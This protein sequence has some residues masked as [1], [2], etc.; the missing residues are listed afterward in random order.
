M[1]QVYLKI[2]FIV[3]FLTVS[4]FAIAGRELSQDY[5]GYFLN[6]DILQGIV[7][8]SLLMLVPCSLFMYFFL[9]GANKRKALFIQKEKSWQKNMAQ[10]LKMNAGLK[11]EVNRLAV[12]LKEGADILE[13][14]TL[15]LS[16]S[17][18]KNSGLGAQLNEMRLQLELKSWELKNEVN[19]KVKEDILSEEV[20][21]QEF[22]KIFP[23]ELSCYRY[24][25]DIKWGKGY[26]CRKC[27]NTKYS[28]GE[29]AYLRKCTRC[30]Y[31]E[32]VTA[33]TLFHGV[34]FS[35]NKAFYIVYTVSAPGACRIT[36]DDLS[37]SISLR[38][39]TCWSFRKKVLDRRED[40]QRQFGISY[41][42]K[43][44]S[45]LLEESMELTEATE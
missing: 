9:N 23:D 8:G 37:E 40:L 24:L 29:K 7:Y 19:D 33:Y 13:N 27:A 12:K 10:Q 20:S 42:D 25:D 28:N 34:K 21:Y 4:S 35:I 11:D 6:A 18:E 5:S 17:I 26:K 44:E 3:F 14:K 38:R 30:K 16:S 41:A 22:S 2:S 36:I 45:L 39:N 31:A 1:G 43:W 32:S 15:E